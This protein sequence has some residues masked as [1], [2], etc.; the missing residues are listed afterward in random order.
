MYACR[1]GLS[2]KDVRMSLTKVSRAVTM[3]RELISHEIN[4]AVMV[5]IAGCPQ[6]P[7]AMT[8]Q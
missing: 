5:A 3:W 2:N 1:F 7:V 8:Q 6:A 4:Y